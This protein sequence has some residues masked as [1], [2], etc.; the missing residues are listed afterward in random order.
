MPEKS[1]SV[2]VQVR[3]PKTLHS[4]S[5]VFGATNSVGLNDVYV[6]ALRSFLVGRGVKPDP[7]VTASASESI[8][9]EVERLVQL[10]HTV[11]NETAAPKRGSRTT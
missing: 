11:Q 6:Q 1:D 4:L 10:A 7:K 8:T 2:L 9:A 3:V 5:K